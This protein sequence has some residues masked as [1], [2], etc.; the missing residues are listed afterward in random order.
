MVHTYPTCDTGFRDN[1]EIFGSIK[2][3]SIIVY[4]V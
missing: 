1:Y 3:I 2:F 4:N